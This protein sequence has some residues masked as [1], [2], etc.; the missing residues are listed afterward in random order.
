MGTNVWK[1]V[2][3]P[4]GKWPGYQSVIDKYN[5]PTPKRYTMP[6]SEEEAEAAWVRAWESGSE[7]EKAFARYEHA[8]WYFGYSLESACGERFG[9]FLRWEAD[10]TSIAIDM[11]YIEGWHG[12][13]E[14]VEPD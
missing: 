6:K 1:N 5:L 12:W 14:R 8:L 10:L 4:K 2:V 9:M 7:Y 3:I 11:G 13:N